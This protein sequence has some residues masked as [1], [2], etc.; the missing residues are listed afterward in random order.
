M[1]VKV[2][3]A[4][5]LRV[6]LRNLTDNRECN[7]MVTAEGQ[8]NRS[9]IENRCDSLP[10]LMKREVVIAVL[11]GDVTEIRSLQILEGVKIKVRKEAG[12]AD[13]HRADAFRSLGGR[14]IA[15]DCATA[16]PRNTAHDNVES[17]KIFLALCDRE[18]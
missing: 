8:R 10:N 13:G 5:T 9:C 6:A 2:K 4:D 1:G 12:V 14:G 15:A 7:S 17:L 11:A 3:N 18:I 16:L